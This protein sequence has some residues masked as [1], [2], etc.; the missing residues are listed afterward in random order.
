MCILRYERLG[1]LGCLV[2]VE[3][4][5]ETHDWYVQ[6]VLISEGRIFELPDLKPAYNQQALYISEIENAMGPIR[7][8]PN[9]LKDLNITIS[10]A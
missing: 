3:H 6:K 10:E 9:N 7:S 5:M 4:K 8:S 1:H 2:Q